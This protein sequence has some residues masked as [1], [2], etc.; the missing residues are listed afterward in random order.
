M[1]KLTSLLLALLLIASL[2]LF[3]SCKK[4][5]YQTFTDAYEKYSALDSIDAKMD[6][7]MKMEMTG[8]TFEMP[9]SYNIKASGIKTQNP[10]FN[11]DTTVSMLGMEMNLDVYSDGEYYYVSMM[12]QKVK[13]NADNQESVSEYNVIEDM[14]TLIIELPEELFENQVFVV[15]PD[16]T[17]SLE[18]AVSG[19]K[20]N[21]LYSDFAK[22]LAD[23]AAE[24]LEYGDLS[25]E[26]IKIKLTV[27][28]DG[29]LSEYDLSF[30]MNMSMSMMG[31]EVLAKIT[32]DCPIDI[33]NPGKE[34]IVTPP[35]DLDSYV[36][37]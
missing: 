15:N 26:D 13:I 23:S 24:G 27:N 34:V 18:L 35:E 31:T 17:K 29:Y 7:K 32:T 20:F 30:V 14:D 6:I 1:K 9:M 28:K 2:P 21:E 25:F 10:V 19:E 5:A 11:A 8:A 22:E 4:S 33:N 3:V 37:Y 36:E 16:G 12:N